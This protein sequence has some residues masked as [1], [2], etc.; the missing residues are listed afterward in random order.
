MPDKAVVLVTGASSGIGR[1]AVIHLAAAGAFVVATARRLE[2]ITDLRKAGDVEC[3]QLDVADDASRSR[4]VEEVVSRFGRVDVLVNNAGYGAN[5]TVEDMPTDKM[6]AM[7]EVNLFG[8]HDLARRLLPQ[9]RQRRSGRIVNVASV[10]GHIA[11]P[12]MGPYCATKFAMRA[13]TQSMDDEVRRFGIRA[14]L[15]EPGWIATK[16]GDRVMAEG[17]SEADEAR[18]P[19]A[20]MYALWRQRRSKP[21]GPHPRV[22]ARKIVHASLSQTP[23]FHNFVPIWASLANLGKRLLPDAFLSWGLRRYFSR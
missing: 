6:R 4:C 12:M 3:L 17:L 19:Y 1:E 11:V 21:R 5:L 8:A 7:F 22:V 10:A 9:M 2:S 14:V 16:F 15:I 20:R 23:R 18:G 13:L